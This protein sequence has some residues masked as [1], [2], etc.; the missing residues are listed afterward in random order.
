ME[1]SRWF[2]MAEAAAYLRMSS[3]TFRNYVSQKHFPYFKHPATGTK[4]FLAADL[5]SVM[6]R[7]NA[8]PEPAHAPAPAHAREKTPITPGDD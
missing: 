7:H 5:D 6:V 1:K 2:T 4:R 3:G 8:E